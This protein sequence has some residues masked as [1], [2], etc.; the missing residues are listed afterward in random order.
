MFK[1]HTTREGKTMM[2]CEMEDTHLVNC[3]KWLLKR[4]NEVRNYRSDLNAVDKILYKVPDASPQQ[5]AN[6]TRQVADAIQPYVLEA[7]LRGLNVKPY[8]QDAFG[9][10]SGVNIDRP[11][12]DEYE[13]PIYELADIL[14]DE[15]V[16]F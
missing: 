6:I 13:E 5:V 10:Q 2:I 16:E 3:I 7:T 14:E 1:T 8:L 15:E 12:F 11:T 4:L 9:R